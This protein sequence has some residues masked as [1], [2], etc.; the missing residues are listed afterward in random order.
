MA[1]RKTWT[2]SSIVTA[3]QPWTPTSAWVV[4][5]DD[6]T[7][8]SL[9]VVLHTPR[10]PA[11]YGRVNVTQDS[12][13]RFRPPDS[14][15]S[16]SYF[17]Q[18]CR[19]ALWSLPRD[20]CHPR[21]RLSSKQSPQQVWTWE[22]QYPRRIDAVPCGSA[23]HLNTSSNPEARQDEWA[24]ALPLYITLAM[25]R[26]LLGRTLLLQPSPPSADQPTMATL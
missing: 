12:G 2:I 17:G 11:S 10:L 23:C 15:A 25:P 24:S 20:G 7:W 22:S 8:V 16:V 19:P 21:P 14:G 5:L 18:Q 9:N 1:A 3:P 6:E 13:C 26:I 4:I